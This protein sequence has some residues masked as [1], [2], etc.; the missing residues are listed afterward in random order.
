[1]QIE[2]TIERVEGGENLSEREMHAAIFAMMSG[3]WQADQIGRLLRALA[4]K[5]ET[6]D[7]VAGAARALREHMSP[8]VTRLSGVLDTCGTGGSGAGLFNVSTAAALVAA[9]AGAPVAKHGNR[10]MSSKTG[11]ADVLELLGVNI[12]AGPETIGRCLDEL[13]IGFCF[14]QQLHPA[15]KHVGP[16]RR[17]L[18]IRT[19]FN[20]LGPLANPAGAP[21]QLLGAGRPELRP[22]L[23]GALRRL[24]TERALVVHG[25]DGIDELSLSAPTRVTEVVGQQVREFTWRP[26]DFELPESPRES[27]LAENPQQSAEMILAVFSG[28]PGPPRDMVVLNAAAALFTADRADSPAEC[29]RLAAAAIDDGSASRGL[30]QLVEGSHS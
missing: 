30:A 2:S 8:I 3:D 4:E 21:R 27:L 18:G 14:A 12:Q 22:L 25:E 9:A 13:G 16:V 10:A 7:E 19:I 15:M 17:Q 26:A 11:S 29:A 6:I 20:I 5:G 24:G 28:Q 1:M 23:A